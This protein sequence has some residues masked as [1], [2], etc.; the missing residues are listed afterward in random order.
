MRIARGSGA[1]T[2]LAG[3]WCAVAATTP[4]SAQTYSFRLDEAMFGRQNQADVPMPPGGG[5]A[6]SCV[7]TTL[8]N[9]YLYLQRA[10]GLNLVPTSV[11]ATAINVG[12]NYTWT[13]SAWGTDGSDWIRGN[14]AY[15]DA[16][17]FTHA[18]TGAMYALHNGGEAWVTRD[19]PTFAFAWSWLVRGG[20]VTVGVSSGAG[21]GHAMLLTGVD[22]TDADSD[23]TLDLSE[24]ATLRFIDPALPDAPTTLAVW[25]DASG[26]ALR[27][28]GGNAYASYN[29]FSVTLVTGTIPAPGAAGTLL[30]AGA[31][32]ARRRRVR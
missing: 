10:F 14:R 2:A 6:N 19:T 27:L 25:Q 7:P 3:C 31:L 21:G 15:L 8:A 24:G 30:A 16:R 20:A 28:S 22:W 32:A 12:T 4:A 13:H 9:S 29:G 18:P 23:G 5:G 11:R 26:G 1:I 17:R